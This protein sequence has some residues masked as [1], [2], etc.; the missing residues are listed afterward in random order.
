MEKIITL[1]VNP[2]LD[3]YT[4]TEKLEPEKKLR[5]SES[6]K[7]AGGGGVNVSRVL[8]RLGHD[9]RTIYSR[10]GYTGEIF[11]QLLEKENI[12]Q[13]PVAIKNDLRQN[14]AVSETSTGKIFRFGFPG[15]TLE[16]AEY[17][18]ILQKLENIEGAKY[19][20]AS[21]SLPP[22]APKDFYSRVA[23]VAKEQG[24]KLIMDTSGEALCE[25]L[26]E[27]AFLIKP[28]SDE[29]QE[30]LG[31]EASNRE[32]LKKL[33]NEV[34]EKF[35]VEAIVLSQGAEGAF[36]ATREG[37]KHFPAPKVDFV[38]S[39]GAGDSMVGGMV[40][41]L[42]KGKSLEDAVLYGISC[43]SATIKSPGTELLKKEDVEELY[44]TLVK[45]VRR[46]PENL[47]T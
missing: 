28:N 13:D 17:E 38:S 37:I 24:L 20:V 39:I 1:T 46:S 14:F 7:D 21:G 34:L 43:G 9:A 16:E 19:L 25:A 18:M 36:L 42:C 41:M 47:S 11:A 29:L 30:I 4:T 33:L 45:Q 35:P 10:G 44:Q 15:A 23:K 2:A 3:I 22:G 12:H 31:K 5:C 32:D 40:A 6:T 27:G 8:K 26:R